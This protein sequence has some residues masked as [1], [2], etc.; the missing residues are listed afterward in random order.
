MEGPIN[1]DAEMKVIKIG[2]CPSLSGRSSLT[3]HIGCRSD[4]LEKYGAEFNEAI[5]FRIHANSGS[6]LFSGQWVPVSALK[7]VF[8]KERSKDAVTSS[9]LNSVFAGTSVNTAGFILAVLKAEGLVV[10]MEDKRRYYQC[11]S[12]DQFF[13][14]M[15]ILADTINEVGTV[16]AADAINADDTINAADSAMSIET[17]EASSAKPMQIGRGKKR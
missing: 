5:S 6:G 9:S 10:H 8:N 1:N 17:D 4:L 16:S 12:T 2:E 7:I 11:A 15:K 3:Y 13:A 14:A